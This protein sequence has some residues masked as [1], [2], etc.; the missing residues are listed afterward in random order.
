MGA[1]V[2]PSLFT[3]RPGAAFG[4]PC[5]HAGFPVVHGAESSKEH[6]LPQNPWNPR[7]I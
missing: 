5:S 3:N 4:I 2:L 1:A 7:A 6:S